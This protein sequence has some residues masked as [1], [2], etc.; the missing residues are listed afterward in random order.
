MNDLATGIHN[1]VSQFARCARIHLVDTG[2]DV[3]HAVLASSQCGEKDLA[4]QAALEPGTSTD[5][6]APRK[7]RDVWSLLLAMA[8]QERFGCDLQL[9]VMAPGVDGQSVWL[10]PPPKS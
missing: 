7:E 6:V 2:G 10:G 3:M 5:A 9:V 8:L 4:S 1:A